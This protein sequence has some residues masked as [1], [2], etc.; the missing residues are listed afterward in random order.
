MLDDAADADATIF[1]RNQPVR[2]LALAKSVVVDR[3]ERGTQTLFV[4]ATVVLDTYRVDI[5]EFLGAQ[6]VLEPQFRRVE[7]EPMRSPIH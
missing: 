1:S 6:D 3:L 5:G 2:R 4:G 7:P